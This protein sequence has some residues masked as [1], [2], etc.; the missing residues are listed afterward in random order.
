[1]EVKMNYKNKILLILGGFALITLGAAVFSTI[2]AGA[3]DMGHA[4]V[5]NDWSESTAGDCSKTVQLGRKAI[6]SPHMEQGST[7]AFLL[8]GDAATANEPRNLGTF[9]VPVAAKLLESEQASSEE[10]EK[11][12][13][14]VKAKCEQTPPA[15]SSSIFLAVKSGA[16][17]LRN[18]GC[19]PGAGKCQIY[20]QSDLQETTEP[21]IKAALSGNAQALKKLPAP[22]DNRGIRLVVCGIAET[23]GTITENKKER[24]LTQNR[25]A[26]QSD[27][28]RQVWGGLF[29]EP[30]SVSF[31][32][33][34]SN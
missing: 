24:K 18:Q 10:Q 19:K 20:V 25:T 8:T 30:Q 1:M 15:Q 33:F 9:P 3:P 26:Q 14:A 11:I 32:P 5:I 7:V 16:E 2:F 6:N 12:L 4:V 29:A 23:K 28:I 21:Q 22:I 34:C 27:L 13:N 17:L 31:N